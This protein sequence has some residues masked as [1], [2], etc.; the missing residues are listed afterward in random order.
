[1]ARDLEVRTAYEYPLSI[2]IVRHYLRTAVTAAERTV[3]RD[4]LNGEAFHKFKNG[5]KIEKRKKRDPDMPPEPK[6]KKK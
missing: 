3:W 6:K 2:K 1:M 5:I 4:L